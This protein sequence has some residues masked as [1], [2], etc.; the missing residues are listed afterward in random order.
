[1]DAVSRLVRCFA[2]RRSAM[3]VSMAAFGRRA[4]VSGFGVAMVLLSLAVPARGEDA[5]SEIAFT[6]DE[7]IDYALEY[8]PDLLRSREGVSKAQGMVGEA[9]SGFLPQVEF[10]ATY[11]RLFEIPTLE[12]AGSGGEAIEVPIGYENNY[13]AGITLSQTLWAWGKTLNA[14]RIADLALDAAEY[15]ISETESS[16]RF[17]VTTAFYG[18][19]VSQEFEKVARDALEQTERH[20]RVIE[21]RQEEG[22]ASRFEL[23]RAR[24][25]VAN[26]KPAVIR[27]GNAVD[28][29]EQRLKLV[30]GMELGSPIAV[31]GD[32]V[33]SSLDLHLDRAIAEAL[34][35]RSALE[36]VRRRRSMATRALS[37]AQ[38][39][40]R[41]TFFASASYMYQRPFY[42]SEDWGRDIRAAIGVTIPLF[43]GFRTRARVAQAKSSLRDLELSLGALEDA[44]ELEVRTAYLKLKEAQE[45]LA[46]QQETVAEAEE[47]LRI[48]EVRFENGMATSLEVMDT[49]L[50]LTQA[51]TNY[52]SALS[53]L[54]VS[55]ASLVRAVGSDVVD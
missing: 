51:R 6:L 35:G 30:M 37:I 39:Q 15:D 7:A 26:A 3:G 10:Q 14:Y 4:L 33:A 44:V 32:L 27:A 36:S 13:T 12:I 23:L 28:L 2:P 8:N 41:P 1:M 5:H 43:D 47:S 50:A 19:M 34:A 9:R 24:V 42:F 49:Q 52:L 18:L 25:Q 53:D 17:A 20:L 31:R 54:L 48:V 29:A 22:L 38:A 11:A 40:N 21:T 45:T 16:V 55:R 46:S